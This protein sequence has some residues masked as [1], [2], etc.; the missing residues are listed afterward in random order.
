MRAPLAG[1]CI[2]LALTGPA[3]A[4]VPARHADEAM[5]V[6]RMDALSS[7]YGRGFDGRRTACG[8]VY[9]RWGN[10]VASPSLPCG[11]QLRLTNKANGRSLLVTVTDR[12]PF[13]RGRVLDVSQGV[14]RK[15]GFETAGL[16]DLR[17]EILR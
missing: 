9:D 17:V 6:W 2:C 12:G 1:L 3:L 5:G 16:A 14:A 15:L 10:T 11:T 8:Q 4:N 13:I 7:F